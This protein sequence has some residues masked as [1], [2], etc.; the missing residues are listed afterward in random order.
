MYYPTYYHFLAAWI[1][2]SKGLPASVLQCEG[3]SRAYVQLQSQIPVLPV[4]SRRVTTL[5]APGGTACDPEG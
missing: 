2:V 3:L 4:P 5:G 1:W